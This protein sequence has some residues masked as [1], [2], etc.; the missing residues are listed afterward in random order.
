MAVFAHKCDKICYTTSCSESAGRLVII[1]K[2]GL[3][4]K[5]NCLGASFG[6]RLV[7]FVPASRLLSGIPVA[8]AERAAGTSSF[9]C[10]CREAIMAKEKGQE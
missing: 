9:P 8:S 7:G 6:T 3:N 5:T 1:L 2:G 10:V 4:A